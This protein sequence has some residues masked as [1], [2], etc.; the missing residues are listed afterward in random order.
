MEQIE[1]CSSY[2]EDKLPN[3]QKDKK[4]D[5]LYHF[6][7]GG[8]DKLVCIVEEKIDEETNRNI[9]FNKNF[10]L[11][12]SEKEEVT[13]ADYFV[14]CFGGQFFYIESSKIKSPKLNILRYLGDYP[15]SNEDFAHLG[16]HSCY[17]LLNG[18]QKIDFYIK[19]A[20]YLGMKYLGISEKNTL[21]SILKFQEACQKENIKPIFGE[22]LPIKIGEDIYIFKFYIK[23]REGYTNL[24]TLSN[25]LNVF[26]KEKE[27]NFILFEDIIKY[28]DNLIIVLPNDFPFE[29]NLLENF[30]I[31]DTYYQIDTIEYLDLNVYHKYLQ[32]IKNYREDWAEI[33]KP[34]LIGDSFYLDKEDK[35]LQDI[36]IKISKETEFKYSVV[37]QHF[38]SIEEHI[39]IF[40]KFW[41]NKEEEFDEFMGMCIENTIKIA[42][43]CNFKLEFEKLHIPNAKIFKKDW[44]KVI[45]EEEK[46]K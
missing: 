14:F 4:Y 1:I 7:Q 8:K 15:I 25:L 42:E 18:C 6:N 34:V 12:L 2:I 44:D 21:S 5:Y 40:S 10:E 37:S 11:I 30:N 31:K 43:K 24:V 32:N 22:D 19:K 27:E 9:L 26:A 20:K 35:E 36:L 28:L 29:E 13:K 17:S 23:N 16:I 39:E 45:L 41:N 38:K 33:I 46:Y 3:F